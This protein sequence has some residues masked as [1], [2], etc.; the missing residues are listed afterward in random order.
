MYCVDNDKFID[1]LLTFGNPHC[2]QKIIFGMHQGKYTQD[3]ISETYLMKVISL[4]FEEKT[5][6]P[7]LY[8]NHLF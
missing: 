5:V 6:K 7:Y 8:Q 1:T 2:L 4:I 3:L